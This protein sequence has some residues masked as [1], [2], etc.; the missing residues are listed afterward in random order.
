MYLVKK[1]L[2]ECLHLG[3]MD[4]DLEGLAQISAV[5]LEEELRRMICSVS[6]RPGRN[7][8]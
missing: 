1:T 4:F 3:S 7:G 8:L 5:E 2:N 6:D